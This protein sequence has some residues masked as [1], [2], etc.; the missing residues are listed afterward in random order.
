MASGEDPAD[1][2]D[3]KRK[4]QQTERSKAAE[5]QAV[6]GSDGASTTA[7]TTRPKKK[8]K[9]ASG[10]KK[11]VKKVVNKL[12]PQKSS[13]SKSAALSAPPTLAS[14]ATGD[15]HHSASNIGNISEFY[16]QTNNRNNLRQNRFLGFC[17]KC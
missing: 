5:A 17:K 13:A 8:S 12:A 7:S 15:P 2:I 10:A 6:D 4:R 11:L 14:A 3:G 9:I 1:I 16:S